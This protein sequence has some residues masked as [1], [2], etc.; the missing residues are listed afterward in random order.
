MTEIYTNVINDVTKNIDGIM[1]KIVNI[2][3]N[4]K[5]T[6]TANDAKQAVT[7]DCRNIIQKYKNVKSQ[8]T[9]Q[10][11]PYYNDLL[12]KDKN[13]TDLYKM[14]LDQN[15]GLDSNIKNFYGDTL[16]NNRKSF[17]ESMALETLV[18]WNTFFMY[19]YF[20]L[21]FAFILGILFSPHRLPKYQSVIICLF[22][23]LYPFFIDPLISE[24]YNL[25][26]KIYNLY[27]K[28]VYNKL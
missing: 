19:L 24:M 28:N 1:V 2:D 18:N 12:L 11:V 16:T 3:P 17:Y 21:F 5:T 10:I 23:F 7:R 13:L 25:F 8:L 6:I 4:M 22:L 20:T 27:P 26:G 15:K 14:Y 9:D